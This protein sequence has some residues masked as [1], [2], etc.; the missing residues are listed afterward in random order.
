MP[1]SPVPGPGGSSDNAWMSERDLVVA[2]D[3]TRE[4]LLRS[5]LAAV[6]PGTALR[7]GL[8][9]ILRGR[10]GALIVLGYD[11]AVEEICTGGFP[12]DVEFSATRLRELAKMDGAHRHRPRDH[13]HPP[14]RRAV[15]AR[16]R[17]RD[18][19][20]RHPAP[21]R[22]AGREADRLPGDLGQRSRCGSSRSTSPGLRYVLEGSDAILAKA[23]QA[24]ATLERYKARLDEVTQ[25]AVGAGDRG[26][27][28]GPGRLDRRPAPGDGAPDLRGDRALRGRARHRRPAAVAAARRADRRRRARTATWS[29]ATTW[30]APAAT[31]R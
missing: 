14:R 29:S 9:R 8:E 10:T 16:L 19:R 25:H 1:A 4:D 20:V 31:G 6:A 11:E 26:P 15:G 27:R 7:D 28:H 17:D 30:R 21:H 24:L 2:T 13:P 22:R 18:Q 5:T 12:L 23:N 3:R